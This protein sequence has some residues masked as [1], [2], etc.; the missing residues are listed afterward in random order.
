VLPRDLLSGA[1]PTPFAANELTSAVAEF[2]Q[3]A[4]AQ[5]AVPAQGGQ[6]L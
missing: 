2:L 3:F 5:Y 1:T 4:N 6:V